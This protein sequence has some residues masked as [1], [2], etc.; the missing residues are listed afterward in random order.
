VLADRRVR[1]VEVSEYA[2]LRDA[3]LSAARLI[4][5]LLVGGLGR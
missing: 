1:L 4:V 3:D 5:D 2:T